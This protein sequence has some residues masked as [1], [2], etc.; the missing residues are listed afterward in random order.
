MRVIVCGAVLLCPA[1][2][3]WTGTDD[4]DDAQPSDDADGEVITVTG[5]R[6]LSPQLPTQRSV[7]HVSRQDLERRLPRSA[8][9]ALRY[10]PGVFVQQTAHGQGSAFIRGVTGQQTLL[11]FD[12]VRLNNSTYRQG[13]NQYFF[14]LD[15]HSVQS[16]QIA[17]GGA[18]TRYGSDAI[19]G[20]VLA[21]P[22]E[23][24]AELPEH[25]R[26]FHYV[27]TIRLR[28]ASADGEFGGRAQLSVVSKSVSFI[29]GA[30]A[31]RVGE[32]EAGG[33]VRNPDDGLVPEVPRFDGDGRT[34]LGTGFRELTADGRVV[35][36]ASRRHVFRAAAY[37]Y[38]QFDAPR[39]DQCP[40]AAAPFD[41]CLNYDE[42]FRT[43]A[44]VVWEGRLG[45]SIVD[46]VRTSVSW[47]RQHER[48]TLRRPSARVENLG[49]DRVDTFGVTL[50]AETVTKRWSRRLKGRLRYG[51]DTYYDRL[52]SAAWIAFTDI[53]TVMRR[54][55]GQY[56]DDSRY[57]YG[58][59]YIDGELELGKRVTLRGG[60][61]ASVTVA[62][63]A[64]D[65]DSGSRAIRRSWFPVVG[66]AG[67][68]WRAGDGVSVLGN[69][70][71][72]FRAPN[73]DDLTSRQQTG[74]GFQFE[75]PTLAPETA[76]TTEVG[77]R[78]SG[79]VSAELWAFRTLLRDAVLKS[80]REQADCPLNSPQCDAAW[81]RFQLVNARSR[82]EIRG[83]EASVHVRFGGALRAR[84]GA[85]YTWGE[86]PN[87]GDPGAL[88]ERVPLSR[89]PPIHGTAELLWRHS[90]GWAWSGG[91]RWAL[92]QS[93]LALADVSDARIPAGGTP[94]FVTVDTQA[95]YRIP[96]K[97][98]VSLAV[99]NVFDAAYR[100]HGSS[101]NGPGL[102]AVLS[103]DLGP[104]WR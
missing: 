36:R 88:P 34:Q 49:R 38:R 94:G 32:L 33:I 102:G 19:G 40:A 82:S 66:N 98:V 51:A 2:V 4:A 67:L 56:I 13:P 63:A 47:Q 22:V 78:F 15:S 59:A 99:E 87:P 90:S 54:S 75:N 52:G 29:G 65:D 79:R 10:E 81:T 39:T 76:T 5:D 96:G 25:A 3:G 71:R 17:R 41:E 7:S 86:G 50:S 16:I 9:D 103:V 80:P 46:T 101:V 14:T 64:A 104:M 43:L 26:H 97:L 12:G 70:D 35:Y 73:L 18:S 77:V 6:P 74:P 85:S 93:R 72:S 95:S 24:A 92:T 45:R 58:G 37:A 27:P 30:G 1:S 28:G 69:V 60:G 57:L 20:V 68:E 83:V 53:G 62:R 48:R 55:R 100:Y 61:R 91:M 42:Q 11:L 84:A 89:I 44:Y 8:P 21:N 23:P 31:R